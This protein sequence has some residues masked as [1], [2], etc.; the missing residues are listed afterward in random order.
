MPFVGFPLSFPGHAEGLAR[1][2]ARPD[3]SLFG[4]TGEAEGM[5]KSCNSCEEVTLGKAS[6]VI[7]SNIDN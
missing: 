7:R 3:F 2:A 5:A 4:E 1:T 6:E